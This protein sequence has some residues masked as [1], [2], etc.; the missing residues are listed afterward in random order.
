MA[1]IS[2]EKIIIFLCFKLLLLHSACQKRRDNIEADI[3]FDNFQNNQ[4]VVF[5]EFI[6]VPQPLDAES[7]FIADS[8]LFCVNRQ[9]LVKDYLFYEYSL[10]S[11]K[12]IGKYI[13]WGSKENRTIAPMSFGSYSNNR[14]WAHDLALKKVLVAHLDKKELDDSLF[15]E[16]FNVDHFAFSTK[17]FDKDKLLSTG[18]FHVP[19]YITI[20]D[21]TSGEL[22]RALGKFK[23]PNSKLPLNNWKAAFEG[24]LFLK[25]S[26][27]KAVIASRYTDIIRIFDMKSEEYT[28]ISGPDHYMPKFVPGRN[29][30]MNDYSIVVSPKTKLAFIDGAVTDNYIYLIYSGKEHDKKEYYLGREIFVFDWEGNQVRRLIL[31]RGIYDIAVTND[32]K[33]I[34]AADFLSKKIV[35]TDL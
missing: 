30:D 26:E 15:I 24:L 9:N 25:P 35:K 31:D 2:N 16:E 34:Y 4:K 17:M 7:I 19:Q 33:T 22:V 21:L 14:I 5:K 6:D 23:A 13:K 3:I 12:F 11:G 1:F 28:T 32:D 18:I 27:E 8:S 20:T 29:K 10:N